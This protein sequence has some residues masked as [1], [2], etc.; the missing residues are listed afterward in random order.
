MPQFQDH[1]KQAKNNIAFLKDLNLK[2]DSYHDW[3]VTV[4]FYIAVH[5]A[6][7]HLAKNGLQFR[8]HSSVNH[9]LNPEVQTSITKID[10]D[11]YLAYMKLFN[12]SRRSRYLTSENQKDAKSDD[13]F[14]TYDK[15]F[16]KALRYLDKILSYF[17]M[18]HAEEFDNIV[19]KC[20]E[21]SKSENLNYIKK[22]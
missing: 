7:A 22:G 1:I 20:S 4:C 21:I 18:K 17:S 2:I 16:A 11:T 15:H 12:L 3:Q 5:L 19:I 8:K 10:E 9:A 14:P 13:S 6:N